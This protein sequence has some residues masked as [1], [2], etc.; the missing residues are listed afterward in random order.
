M[1]NA[2]LG[3]V[4]VTMTY[5]THYNGQTNLRVCWVATGAGVHSVRVPKLAQLRFMYLVAQTHVS[6]RELFRVFAL[7][8]SC[9]AWVV[10]WPSPL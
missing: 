7:P 4:H 10:C 6:D 5:T 3:G 9:W 2:T 8:C 1:A